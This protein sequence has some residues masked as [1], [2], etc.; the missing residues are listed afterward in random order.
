[1]L[2][3]A[4]QKLANPEHFRHYYAHLVQIY[5]TNLNPNYNISCN[6]RTYEYD[7]IFVSKNNKIKR[8]CTENVTLGQIIHLLEVYIYK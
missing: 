6:P 2:L 3:Q 7:R 5:Y 1:M 4:S 8:M